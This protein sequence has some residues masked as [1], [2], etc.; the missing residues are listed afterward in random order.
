MGETVPDV[1][2]EVRKSES[3]KFWSWSFSMHTCMYLMMSRVNGK[4]YKDGQRNKIQR[5]LAQSGSE[6]QDWAI[7]LTVIEL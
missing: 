7:A 2:T 1:R 4:G 5:N 3:Q 6:K